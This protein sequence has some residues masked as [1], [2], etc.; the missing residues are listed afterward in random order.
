[1]CQCSTG[2]PVR[3]GSAEVSTVD[4]AADHCGA[5]SGPNTIR[6]SSGGSA[7]AARLPSKAARRNVAVP[8]RND[9]EQ[10]KVRYFMIDGL[11]PN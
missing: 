8:I 11:D 2:E 3:V 4:S 1:M 7:P 5:D 9:S 6:F 10:T